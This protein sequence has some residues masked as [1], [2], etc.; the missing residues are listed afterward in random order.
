MISAEGLAAFAPP[1]CPFRYMAASFAALA[2]F[3]GSLPVSTGRIFAIIAKVV[4]HKIAIIANYFLT[5][6][7]DVRME[8]ESRATKNR[9]EAAGEAIRTDG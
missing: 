3:S 4:K 2:W 1:D 6:P 9:S 5:A 8:D 7:R